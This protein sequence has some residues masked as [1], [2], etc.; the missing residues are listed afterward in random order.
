MI[1][2]AEVAG[3]RFASDTIVV[4]HKQVPL[5]QRVPVHLAVEFLVRFQLLRLREQPR[6][7]AGEQARRLCAD[8]LRERVIDPLPTPTIQLGKQLPHFASEPLATLSV[9]VAV[10]KHTLLSAPGLR[11]STSQ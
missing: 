7:A 2:F 10:S 9:G 6:L 11:P 1:A 5:D 8:Q 4:T 3:F